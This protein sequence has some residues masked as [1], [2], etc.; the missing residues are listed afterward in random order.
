MKDIFVNGNRAVLS[1]VL[2]KS[3]FPNFVY[4]GIISYEKYTTSDYR[5]KY[6]DD[7]GSGVFPKQ[8]VINRYN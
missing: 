5:N 1:F 3:I 2:H 6:V 4:N 8:K 7:D